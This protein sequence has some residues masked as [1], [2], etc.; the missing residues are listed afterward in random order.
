MKKS[1]YF[2]LCSLL[3]IL[4][5]VSIGKNYNVKSD[6]SEKIQYSNKNVSK[7]HILHKSYKE[8]MLNGVADPT[9]EIINLV[10]TGLFGDIE[11]NENFKYICSLDEETIILPGEKPSGQPVDFQDG[12]IYAF[13]F[14][15]SYYIYSKETI[16]FPEDSSYLFSQNKNMYNI[17]FNNINT[18]LVTN[19]SAMFYSNPQLEKI[20]LSK[21]NTSNVTNMSQM[22]S[23]KGYYD[24]TNNL[25]DLH[26]LDKLDTSNV[27]NM[28]RMF[29]DLSKIEKLNLSEFDTSNVTNLSEMFLNC[30]SIKELDLSH[31]KIENVT[32]MN[33]MFKG[34]SNVTKI[35]FS[36]MNGLKVTSLEGLFADCNNLVDLDFSGRF[37]NVESTSMMFSYCI[38]LTKFNLS[39]L[40]IDNLKNM[41]KMFAGC[42]Q[43][44][45]LN[46][47]GFNT[48]KVTNMSSLFIGCDQLVNLDL[49][50]LDTRSVTNMS[51][52]FSGCSSLKNV[53]LKNLNTSNV[54]DMSYMFAGCPS[55]ESLDFSSFNTSK[56]E[57]FKSFL[58]GAELLRDF[59]VTLLEFDSVKN[60]SS[61][62]S[63]MGISPKI[64]Y[65]DLS[66]FNP[67]NI[68]NVSGMFEETYIHKIN[69]VNYSGKNNLGMFR[70]LN[71]D[72]V[73]LSD[74]L[75]YDLDFNAGYDYFDIYKN[76]VNEVKAGDFVGTVYS[77]FFTN[78]IAIKLNY[79]MPNDTVKTVYS[80]DAYPHKLAFEGIEN[81]KK[82]VWSFSNT[83]LQEVDFNKELNYTPGD[84]VYDIYAYQV[85]ITTITIDRSDLEYNDKLTYNSE[86]Q[87]I[88]I[89]NLDTI[90]TLNSIDCEL[91]YKPIY[92]H[93]AG[94]YS[95]SVDYIYD[96]TK[97]HIPSTVIN[98]EVNKM[99]I[100]ITIES[101]SSI[102][103]D[104]LN[105]IKF[106]NTG[107]IFNNE[108]SIVPTVS[109]NGLTSVGVYDISVEIT[110]TSNYEIGTINYAKYTILK[111]PISITVSNKG[112]DEMYYGD[113]PEELIYTIDSGDLVSSKDIIVSLSH[114]GNRFSNIGNYSFEC[115]VVNNNYNVSISNPNA[116]VLVIEPR[117]ITVKAHSGESV[118]GENIK[119]IEM[120]IV[121]I[122]NNDNL[123]FR[124]EHDL[125]NKTEVGYYGMKV[126]HD[127]NPNYEVYIDADPYGNHLS[128]KITKKEISM[129]INEHESEYGSEA[130]E[131]KYNIIGLVN[132]DELQVRFIHGVSSYSPVNTY[133]IVLFDE[134]FTNYIIEYLPGIYKVVPREIEVTLQ[135]SESEVG[136]PIPDAKYKLSNTIVHSDKPFLITI[137]ATSSS[138]EGVYGFNI[139]NYNDL[140]YKI[141]FTNP[142]AKLHTIFNNRNIIVTIHDASS[143]YGEDLDYPKYDVV[144][145]EFVELKNIRFKGLP[146]KTSVAGIYEITVEVE[147][148]NLQNPIIEVINAKYTI[149]PREVSI[150]IPQIKTF[151]GDT[152]EALKYNIV[153]GSIVNDDNIVTILSSATQFS[154]IGSYSYVF[155]NL[156]NSY[157]I[158]VLNDQ[159]VEDNGLIVHIISK[160]KLTIQ[161]E[162]TDSY[163]YADIKNID[164]TVVGDGILFEI[165]IPLLKISTNADINKV[166]TYTINATLNSENY[167][168]TAIT[169]VYKILDITIEYVNEILELKSDD[170]K[171]NINQNT[172]DT[173]LINVIQDTLGKVAEI[174]LKEGT[175]TNVAD[176]NQNIATI[177]GTI[178]VNIGNNEVHEIDISY[179]IS[180]NPLKKS[181]TGMIIGIVVSVVVV[182]AAA[183]GATTFVI[184]RKR[185]F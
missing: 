97:Y 85:N 90:K 18:S 60:S 41:S 113:D 69:L 112:I 47:N 176:Y 11:N 109:I 184:I 153:S 145:P 158:T 160:R 88:I 162:D 24:T 183:G 103:G 13:E 21:F 111:R 45:N 98:V 122:V 58:A 50:S 37:I 35:N 104:K 17:T 115:N 79:H 25:I 119:E 34:M 38:S 73:I 95:L 124:V 170:I 135:E 91:D 167:D 87:Y 118:Y 137:D 164:Y 49:S 44:D 71:A 128:Y 123:N 143:I 174:S 140:N 51:S 99:K 23:L 130:L 105:Q 30:S 144:K 161:L 154:S 19:M 70:E 2:L 163:L 101:N 10:F 134:E 110:H 96:E 62:F 102:Y 173:E 180:I 168:F 57:N 148:L 39:D 75:K 175:Y 22:F 4:I 29:S 129:I 52:M 33:S 93:D 42:T 61:M 141:I 6:V 83:E 171:N 116:I 159:G 89:K 54:K 181:N 63:K 182:L 66:H 84:V 64:D 177:T 114:V 185:R 131:I 178:L 76:A 127:D 56:V 108:V 94:T 15:H 166:G 77:L 136:K 8:A 151:Y 142:D 138:T 106:I 100:D 152:T 12:G 32:K 46:F 172:N 74:Y 14:N 28:S 126:I 5:F 67:E 179:T 20:N 120:T 1:R 146:D 78:N 9:S 26:Y 132:N 43:L 156:H 117:T 82:Y 40:H 139:I 31:F 86:N 48:S 72:I 81:N 150:T 68:E 107:T 59:D 92:V 121:N 27:V 36:K 133:E 147:V 3:L 65:L 53:N 157:N 169:A 149:I 7:K 55:L 155:E 125:N 16:Y 80:Y 165:D